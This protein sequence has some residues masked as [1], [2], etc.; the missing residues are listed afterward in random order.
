MLMR[1]NIMLMVGVALLL[2]SLSSCKT[3]SNKK[4]KGGEKLTKTEGWKN[5]ST[6]QLVVV[7]LWD[8]SQYYI[9]GETPQD[10]KKAKS[11]IG[12]QADSK[13]AAQVKAMRDFKAKMGEVIKSRTGVDDG[14]LIEDVIESSLEGVSISPASLVENYTS[15]HDCRVTFEFSAKN[16]K[17]T[18]DD[19]ANSVLNK[20]NNLGGVQTSEGDL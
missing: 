4:F 13:R 8:R 14:N 18:V 1:S 6:Y 11:I 5:D 19:M 7:G 9:E 10:G 17:K 3:T 15:G 16:L 2:A 20:K 12:L